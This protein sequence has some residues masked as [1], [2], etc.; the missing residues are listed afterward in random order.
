MRL[1][2][3]SL[4]SDLMRSDPII[5][6]L[7]ITHELHQKDDFR[8]AALELMEGKLRITKLNGDFFTFY[9]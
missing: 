2:P 3:A 6:L 9:A 4:N 8:E 7:L 1:I 5:N